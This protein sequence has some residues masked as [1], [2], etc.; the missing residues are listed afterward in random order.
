MKRLLR[1]AL[2]GTLALGLAAPAFADHQI[3]GYFRTQFIMEEMGGGGFARVDGQRK[4]PKPVT[5]VD[6]RLRIRWQNNINEYV[7]VVWFGEIDTPWG[8]P[9]KGNIGAGGQLSSDGVNIETKHAYLEVKIPDTP[10]STR[11]GMQGFGGSFDGAIMNDDMAGIRLD[12]KMDMFNATLFW[13]KYREGSRTAEDDIDL[14][15]A[16]FGFAPI[17]DL[18]FGLE[19]YFQNNQPGDFMQYWVGAKAGYKLA[20]VDLAGW[21]IY[22][23]GT[24]ESGA[25]DVDVSAWAA[26]LKGSM[27]LA[28]AK[29]DL[30]LM[31]YSKDDDA[32]D[33]GS[34]NQADSASGYGQGQGRFEYFDAG[35]MIMLADVDYNN[36]N[37]GRLALNDA[38][39]AGYGLFGAVVTGRYSPPAMKNMYAQAAV[40]F[41][42]ALD[43]KHSKND[44]TKREGEYLGTEFAAKV[45][46]KIA[47][48]VDV[49]LRG[50]YALLGDFYDKT[51]AEGKDPDDLYKL[52][53]MVNV[54]Y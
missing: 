48:N 20:P 35:L 24:D 6:N 31:Y 34:F 29:V 37:G 26:F 43:D 21:F 12:A 7:T 36:F 8:E 25:S 50:A 13:S 28:G 46:C 16:Q 11:I 3:G 17:K 19:G 44:L 22:N 5:G 10:L 49:S 32:T 42:T 53:A 27:A 47:G 14:Y 41:F 54:P 33:D 30:R 39:Y 52:I 15:V 1:T 9:S 2:V 23:F 4:D 38:A 40:G 18:K 45:G 51:N